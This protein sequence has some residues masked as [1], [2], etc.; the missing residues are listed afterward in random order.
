MSS[1]NVCLWCVCARILL[2]VLSHGAEPVLLTI[3]VTDSIR[4]GI[5][6][7]AV[8][9]RVN[10]R[11]ELTIVCCEPLSKRDAKQ[12]GALGRWSYWFELVITILLNYLVEVQIN[13]HTL[14]CTSTHV[15]AI[16]AG[17]I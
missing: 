8:G 11:T 17:P 12:P 16:G 1:L 13:T 14:T 4:G 10:L 5:L 2:S 15:L 3:S 7:L 6:Y 9:L